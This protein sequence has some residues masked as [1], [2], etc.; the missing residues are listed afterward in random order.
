MSAEMILVLLQGVLGAAPQL[1]ALFT[2]AKAG[3]AVS[4]TQVA[5]VLS[6][7]G[8][9]RAVFAAAIAKAEAAAGMGQTA[10]SSS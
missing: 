1:L 4:T 9:D 7:Y 6:Q 2:Q 10:T 3:Q 5:Q 8:I